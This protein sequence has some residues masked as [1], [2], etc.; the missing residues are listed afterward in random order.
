MAGED[1]ACEFLEKKNYKIIKRNFRCRCGEV[2]IIVSKDGELA[3]VEVK[4]WD[5]LSTFDLSYVINYKKQK[6]ITNASRVFLRDYKG[7]YT[8]FRF[9]VLLITD[10]KTIYEYYTNILMEN[11]LP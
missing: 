7:E 1:A 11:G 8:S 2:D 5:A 4:T 9:D 10:D 6:R 3:F